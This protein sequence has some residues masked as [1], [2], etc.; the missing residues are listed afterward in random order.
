[1]NFNLTFGK[2]LFRLLGFSSRSKSTWRQERSVVKQIT[3]FRSILSCYKSESRNEHYGNRGNKCGL[4][5]IWSRKRKCYWE[6]GK[7]TPETGQF[8]RGSFLWSCGYLC[9]EVLS[10]MAQVRRSHPYTNSVG[11]FA[12]SSSNIGKRMNLVVFFFA[13]GKASFVRLIKF[14]PRKITT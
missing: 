13:W 12:H 1:M 5:L 7:Q 4:P 9:R 11:T 6:F 8:R 10:E 14:S 2:T 3:L